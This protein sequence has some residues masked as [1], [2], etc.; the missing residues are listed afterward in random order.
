M[1]DCG[2][3]GCTRIEADVRIGLHQWVVSKPGKRA[4]LEGAMPTVLNN[5]CFNAVDHLLG[6]SSTGP[7]QLAGG[8]SIKAQ[9]DDSLQLPLSDGQQKLSLR[10]ANANLASSSA[11]GTTRTSGC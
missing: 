3:E 4:K 10:D 1:T 6:F 8:C 11:S 7:V 9:R 2:D 5:V